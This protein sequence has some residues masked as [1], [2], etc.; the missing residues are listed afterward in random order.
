MKSSESLIIEAGANGWMVMPKSMMSPNTPFIVE[1]IFMF[2]KIT[3]LSE[4]I[5]QHFEK[6]ERLTQSSCATTP[7]RS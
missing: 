2:N 6:T 3:D 4:F 5:K 7:N 1:D